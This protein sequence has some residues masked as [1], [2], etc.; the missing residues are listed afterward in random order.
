MPGS[1]VVADPGCEEVVLV[2]LDLEEF[3][4]GFGFDGCF[5]LF[6]EEAEEQDQGMA[7]EEHAEEHED[8]R[9]KG[10][11]CEASAPDAAGQE[12]DDHGRGEGEEPCGLPEGRGLDRGQAVNDLHQALHHE[13]GGQEYENECDEPGL[14]GEESAVE[15]C[16]ADEEGAG[17]DHHQIVDDE[18]I[19]EGDDPDICFYEGIEEDPE[20][21]DR[22]VLD[23]DSR[24]TGAD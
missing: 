2:G 22:C 8:P 7:D 17:T 13:P 23:V 5:C 18:D 4:H 24:E 1:A 20:N 14:P 6:F 15:K 10:G 16:L 3:F 21:R 19:L 9:H 11:L 12:K